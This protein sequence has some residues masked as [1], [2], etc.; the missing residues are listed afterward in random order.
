MSRI[1]LQRKG[2]EGA[3]LVLFHGWG[4]DSQIW[5]PFIPYLE[6]LAAFTEIIR[7]DLPGFGQTP[8]QDW[9]EFSRNLLSLL[10]QRF[11]LMGWSLGGL[12]AARLAIEAHKRVSQLICIASSPYF[13]REGAWPGIVEE[14]LTNF[15]QEFIANP[16]QT[17]AQFVLSQTGTNTLAEMSASKQ[18]LTQ[19]LHVLQSW[20]LREPM[21]KLDLPVTY[22]LGGMDAIVPRRLFKVMQ[23]RYPRFKGH[24]LMDA[25][26]IPFISHPESVLKLLDF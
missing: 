17:Q 9:M 13:I 20:D 25:A 10:P 22:I 12:F 3:S 1:H 14:K 6:S 16:N 2:K 11:A 4:F 23:E 18:G 8:Y 5:Q 7:V 21:Q 19:G 24:L 15:Y 26:H